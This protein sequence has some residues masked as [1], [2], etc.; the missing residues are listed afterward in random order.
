VPPISPRHLPSARKARRTARP[1]RW[2]LPLTAPLDRVNAIVRGRKL[3]RR[4]CC[5]TRKI[6]HFFPGGT[7][8]AFDISSS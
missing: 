5:R 2:N 3:S 4:C 7:V 6:G 8:D 1:E